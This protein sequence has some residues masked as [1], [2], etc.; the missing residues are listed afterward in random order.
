MKNPKIRFILAVMLVALGVGGRLIRIYYFPG[1]YNVEP[2]TAMSLLAGAMLG[3]G[4]ALTVP[5]SMV[6]LSDMVIGNQPIMIFTWSAWAAIGVLGMVLRKRKSPSVRFS[7]E[8]TGMGIV[9]SLLF[10]LWTNFGVWLIDGIYPHTFAGLMQSYIM[11]LPFLKN[12][13]YGNLVI[14]PVVS[15]AAILAWKTVLYYNQKKNREIA[16]PTNI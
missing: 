5:L 10:Y 11:G 14:V 3:G 2:F 12:Q 16:L 6:A 1:L 7:L 15:L 4:Y 8:L 9:A 13:I